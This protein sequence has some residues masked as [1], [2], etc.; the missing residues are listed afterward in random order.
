MELNNSRLA[1]LRDSRIALTVRH[2]I[3]L[4]ATDLQEVIRPLIS[5]VREEAESTMLSYDDFP[6]DFYM[7]NR[8]FVSSLPTYSKKFSD[9]FFEFTFKRYEFDSVHNWYIDLFSETEDPNGARGRREEEL[10]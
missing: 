3:F 5:L 7:T 6:Q 9:G 8:S 1:K 2:Q 4:G 10:I